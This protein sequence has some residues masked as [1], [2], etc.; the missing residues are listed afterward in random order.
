MTVRLKML[1]Q[2]LALAMAG[3]VAVV[4]GSPV[5]GR[6]ITTDQLQTNTLEAIVRGNWPKHLAFLDIACLDTFAQLRK[7]TGT[8][9]YRQLVDDDLVGAALA[10]SAFLRRVTPDPEAG[11]QLLQWLFSNRGALEEFCE[12]IK[13]QDDLSR[14]IHL[15]SELWEADPKGHEKYWKLA[16]ACALVFDHPLSYSPQTGASGMVDMR[17]RYQYYRDSV[18]AGEPCAPLM[19]LAPWELVWVVDAPIPTSEL[20]WARK[21]VKLSRAQWGQAYGMIQ[22]RMD[23]ALKNAKIYDKYTLAEIRQKGGICIDQAY[24]AAM[25]AKA[26][27]IPAMIFTG[28]G[29]RGPH[30]WFGYKASPQSWNLKTGRYQGDKYP[31][32]QTVDP[33]TRETIKEQ[34]LDL[35]TDPQ[36]RQPTYRDT[37]RLVWL[38]DIFEAYGQADAAREALEQA[39]ATSSRHLPAWNALYACLR[40]YGQPP[41]KLQDTLHTMR[42]SFRSYPDVIASINQLEAM[43]STNTADIAEAMRQQHRQLQSSNADRT[44]LLV[45]NVKQRAAVFEQKNDLSSADAVYRRALSEEGRRLAA[46]AELVGLYADFARKHNR[47]H[48]AVRNIYNELRRYP[49]PGDD[50]F[51]QRT[52][53]QFERRV[54]DLLEE[55]KQIQQAK[56]LRQE[57]AQRE[58]RAANQGHR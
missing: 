24:F 33:Q 40:K 31:A 5:Q 32:G 42:M 39:V 2:C 37:S 20:V 44:D 23:R 8:R 34:T 45:G 55:D 54:A 50:P 4:W 1:S 38:A 30:A 41:K 27:S 14:V 58:Q 21:N 49:I 16:L 15:W 10:Q 28:M 25:T 3:M 35:L 7:F 18:E 19:E 56:T 9:R 36:Q 22:Y 17:E 51:A 47:L 29:E 43:T 46:F 11:K 26:N 13:P 57:A 53:A 12:T 48:D 6:A 52:Y